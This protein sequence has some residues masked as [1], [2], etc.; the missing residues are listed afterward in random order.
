MQKG[1]SLKNNM[2]LKDNEIEVLVEKE[3]SPGRYTGRH[4]GQAPEIDGA[5]ILR[6]HDLTPG[7]Y[8]EN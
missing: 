4:A 6:G 3:S 1:I 2:G 8:I 5:T 7:D